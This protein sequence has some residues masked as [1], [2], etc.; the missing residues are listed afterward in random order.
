MA[1]STRSSSHGR[2]IPLLWHTL[3]HSRA[4]ISA[5]VSIA[6]L[7][8][9]DRLLAGFSEITLLADRAFP[10][11]EL[12]RG[13]RGFWDEQNRVAKLQQ[14]KP[15]LRRLSESI[16]RDTFRPLLEQGYTQERKSHAGRKRIDPLILFK[17]L[18]LQQLFNLSD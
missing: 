7:E 4:S 14:K 11:A 18:I 10:C 13:Q 15:V 3:E 6:L 9:A 16:P 8:K 5:S 12:L 2:A 17:M 1:V